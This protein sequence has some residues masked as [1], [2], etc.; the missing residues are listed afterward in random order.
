MNL[1]K[2]LKNKQVGEDLNENFTRVNKNFKDFFFVLK[3]QILKVVL[4]D[5]HLK[6]VYLVI[7][8]LFGFF[9]QAE[10]NLEI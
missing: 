7:K 9:Y 3:V 4:L 1:V 10:K 2:H 5:F 6:K 8:H